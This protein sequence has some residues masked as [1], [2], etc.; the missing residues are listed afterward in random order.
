MAYGTGVVPAD[1]A[2]G[3]AYIH[4]SHG[5][6]NVEQ[7][8]DAKLF[9]DALP[10]GAPHSGWYDVEIEASTRARLAPGG[11]E[12][13]DVNAAERAMQDVKAAVAALSPADRAGAA[14]YVSNASAITQKFRLV[15][16]GVRGSAK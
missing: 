15:S 3:P 1:K 4:M 2:G 13:K 16:Q 5:I 10:E 8:Y 9:L 6:R 11:P 14:C 12:E 7:N